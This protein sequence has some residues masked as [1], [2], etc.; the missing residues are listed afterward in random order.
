MKDTVSSTFLTSDVTSADLSGSPWNK[1]VYRV[2][3]PAPHVNATTCDAMCAFNAK[4]S[5]GDGCHFTAFGGGKC[6]L[7]TLG[8]ETT[9]EPNLVAG[10]DLRLWIG[11]SK[12]PFLHYSIVF[13]K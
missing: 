5:D 4:R 6:Y 9:L 13:R 1:Y 3:G 12:A 10:L 7:G 2:Y 8:L 11:N